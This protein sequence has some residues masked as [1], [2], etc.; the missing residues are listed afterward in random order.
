[1]RALIQRVVNAKV[2]VDQIVAGSIERGMVVFL[3]ILKGDT[4]IDLEYIANKLTN[5]R[6]F[7]DKD[8]KMNLSVRDVDGSILIISQFTLASDC[9][10]G[11]RPSFDMAEEPKKAEK[12]YQNLI[13]KM[14]DRGLNVESGRFG[15][16]MQV[17]LANDG[18]VT[19]LIDSKK[20]VKRYP[21]LV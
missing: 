14:R 15:A 8:K 11:N 2:L 3:G 17:V 6:I 5:L 20:E 19:F 21:N 4:D 10:K 16:Y 9:R 7:E 18:P 12:L 1:M 13:Q